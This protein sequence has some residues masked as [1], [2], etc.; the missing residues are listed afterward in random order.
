MTLVQIKTL[1]NQTLQSVGQESGSLDDFSWID[2]GKTIANLSADD[3]KT[4][5]QKFA[6][7][8]VK[9]E[10]DTRVWEHTLDLFTDWQTYEG[11]KQ[12]IKAAP[13]T[14]D[15]ITMI[16]LVDGVDYDDRVY[17]DLDTSVLLYTKD[18]GFQF[19]W[20]VPQEEL[21][22]LFS[23][24]ESV[25]NYV[26]LINA[27]VSTSFNR[28]KWVTQLSLIAKLAL[29]AYV[30]GKRVDLVTTFNA[31]H[32]AGDAVT[33][34]TAMSS[35]MFKRWVRETVANL[36]EYMMDI[37]SKY[38]ANGVE[39]F[40]PYDDTRV[41]LLT[42]FAHALQNVPAWGDLGDKLV[43]GKYS[44]INMW[45]ASGSSLLPTIATT[46]AITDNAG[47]GT[48]VTAS[49]IVGL[50]YDRYS[51]GLTLKTSKKITSDYVPKGDFTKFFGAMAGQGFI[52]NNNNAI[53]LTLN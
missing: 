10:F 40:T 14:A 29:D 31:T 39:S 48:P 23:N 5:L 42:Q 7:G 17:K 25:V 11:I 53:V 45:Q 30:N 35:D 19:S 3:F 24:E 43:L 36:R 9:T 33:T 1:I 50:L 51:V 6:L 13:L 46:G 15:D 49:N 2:T 16:A 47:G 44:T 8:V 41:T 12:Y 4:F 27:T 34:A 38:N 20:C 32:A 22:Y 28:S 52:N 21:K 37:T 18:F 26:G